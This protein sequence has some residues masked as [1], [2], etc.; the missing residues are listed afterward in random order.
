MA[1]GREARPQGDNLNFLGEFGHCGDVT[2][3]PSTHVARTRAFVAM[4]T[5]KGACVS[6]VARDR[7][8][9][10]KRASRNSARTN[11]QSIR[12]KGVQGEA[13]CQDARQIDRAGGVINRPR[14][15]GGR[16]N[17]GS[18]MEAGYGS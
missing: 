3:Y 1:R 18:C 16:K 10:S 15:E 8:R 6:L 11:C 4:G 7:A 5:S 17:D 9:A 2:P 13:Q 14:T 12:G